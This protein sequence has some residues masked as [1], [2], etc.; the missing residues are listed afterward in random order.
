MF[1]LATPL[2]PRIQP[3]WLSMQPTPAGPFDHAEQEPASASTRH[4][5]ADSSIISSMM[6]A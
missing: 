3:V 1:I 6:L 5:I 4:R 2:C